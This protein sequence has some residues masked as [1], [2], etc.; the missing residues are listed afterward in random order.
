MDFGAEEIEFYTLHYPRSIGKAWP[1]EAALSGELEALRQCMPDRILL[2]N[3][4]EETLRARK[5]GDETR[6]RTFFDHYLRTLWPMKKEW[7]IGRDCV[8]V[9]ETDALTQTETGERVKA[10][11]DAQLA[12][13]RRVK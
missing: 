10:W 8:D 7:F 4:R 9:L 1:V 6:S 11:V 3:A 13:G 12:A 2:L 5:A